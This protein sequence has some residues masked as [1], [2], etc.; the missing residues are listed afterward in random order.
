[1]LGA[2]PLRA[3]RR[4]NTYGNSTVVMSAKIKLIWDFFGPEGQ[5]TA[6]HHCKHLREFVEREAVTY[7]G[8][9]TEHSQDGHSMA[10]LVVEESDVTSL[11]AV[12][13]PSR[14]REV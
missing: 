8:A 14:G 10:W 2:Q 9:G 13:N 3:T 12:L 6:D 11:R 1:M 4:W 7:H 5:R